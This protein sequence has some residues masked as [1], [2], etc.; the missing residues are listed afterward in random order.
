MNTKEQIDHRIEQQKEK[1][2]VK[3]LR[4]KRVD[5]FKKDLKRIMKKWK[6]S[7]CMIVEGD[8][9]GTHSE[10]LAVYIDGEDYRLNHGY[11]LHRSDL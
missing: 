4:E 3:Q 9:H 8:T 11:F 5:S 2:I 6:V 10:G 1:K 7:L